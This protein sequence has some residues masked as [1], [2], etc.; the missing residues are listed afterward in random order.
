MTLKPKRRPTPPGIILKEMYLAPRNITQKAF[1]EAL[2]VSRKHISSIVNG[3]SRIE[4]EIAVRFAKALNTT[5]DVWL[6]LQ[7]AI[8]VWDA[9]RQLK[10]WQPSTVFTAL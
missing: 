2:G 3:R 8:D 1:A 6:N 5:P 4:P 10:I 7:N 9:E